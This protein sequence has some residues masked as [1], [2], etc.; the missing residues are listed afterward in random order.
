MHSF[1]VLQLLYLYRIYQVLKSRYSFTRLIDNDLHKS[2]SMEI[3]I[4]VIRKVY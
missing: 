2:R 3:K 1:P 4:A